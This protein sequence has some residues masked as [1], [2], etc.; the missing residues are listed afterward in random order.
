MTTR[1]A[2][3]TK[4]AE[5][6]VLRDLMVPVEDGVAEEEGIEIQD[7]EAEQD[8]EPLRIARGP[9]LPS[10]EDVGSHRC[11]HIPFR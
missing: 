7:E 4:D 3:C 10:Q 2:S 1:K 11:S 6:G 5:L 9:K 8:A